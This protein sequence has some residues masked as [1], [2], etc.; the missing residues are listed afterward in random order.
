MT[1]QNKTLEEA[2]HRQGGL[3]AYCGKELVWAST[4]SG[5]RGAWHSHHRKAIVHGG[6]DFLGNCVLLCINLPEECHL[7]IGHGGSYQDNMVLHDKDL[8]YLL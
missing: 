2:F 3:C 4:Q 8:P 1:F 6:T 7:Q 5:E